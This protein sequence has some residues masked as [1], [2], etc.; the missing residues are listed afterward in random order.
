[1]ESTSVFKFQQL[2]LFDNTFTPLRFDELK[3]NIKIRN[4]MRY[5]DVLAIIPENLEEGS[6]IFREYAWS[7]LV[8]KNCYFPEASSLLKEHLVNKE[9]LTL[10]IYLNLSFRPDYIVEY[11]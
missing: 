7:V 11:L 10:R 9:P 2:N 3:A 5:C 1:M 8:Y 4:K 6:E